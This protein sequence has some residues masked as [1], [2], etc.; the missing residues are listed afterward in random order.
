MKIPTSIGKTKSI[1]VGEDGTYIATNE[2]GEKYTL[3]KAKIDLNDC[4]ACSGCITTAETILVS[5]HGVD[6]FLNLLKVFIC[7]V[8]MV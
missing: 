6:R 1:T 8:S 4:L 2:S 3:P 5:Q 7:F